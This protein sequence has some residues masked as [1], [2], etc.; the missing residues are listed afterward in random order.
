VLLLML[1]KGISLM[2]PSAQQILDWGGNDAD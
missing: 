1:A 2:E